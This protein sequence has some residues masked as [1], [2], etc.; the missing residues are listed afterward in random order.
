MLLGGIA[1]KDRDRGN[2]YILA[3]VMMAIITL[4]AYKFL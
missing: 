2:T 1:E 4:L 3:T